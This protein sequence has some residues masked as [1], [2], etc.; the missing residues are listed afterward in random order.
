[1][2]TPLILLSLA[3]V[4]TF[5]LAMAQ[6]PS[7]GWG[8]ARWIWDQADA[9]SVAQTDDPRYVRRAFTL[10]AKPLKAELWIAADN[11]YTAYVNG[12]KVGTGT[13]WSKVD[14]YDVAR[15]LTAGKNVL[16]I[17]AKNHG[18]PAG[19]IAR[20]HIVTADKKDTIVGT[21]EQ[22]RV[23]QIA[24]PDWLKV[25]FDDQ[26]WATAAVLGDVT[27][28]P[29]NLAGNAA[30]GGGGQ[31]SF[32]FQVADA[33]IKAQQKAEDQVKNF[34]LPEGFEIELVASDP[35]V[36][37]P[38]TMAVD[39]QGRIYV[40][41]S[42][43]YRYGPSGSPIKPYA[44]PLVRLDPIKPQ[45]GVPAT[46]ARYKR[47]LIADGFDDPVMGIAVKGDKLWVTANNYLYTY[48]LPA[49]PEGESLSPGGSQ[50]LT[51]NPS[52][53]R[54]EGGKKP[55]GLATN[56]KTI[57]IDK[58]KAWNP[59][60]MFV[61]EWGPDGMLYMSVGN[62]GMDLQGPD[63]KITSRGGSGIIVRMN[64]DGSK[65]ERLV[66]GLRVPY[67]FEMD[68]FGQLWLLSNGEGNPDRFVRV[69][70]GVDYHCFSRSGVDNV[71]LAGNHPLAPPCFEL[72][73]GAHTQLMRYY[74][75]AFPK[76]YQGSLLACNWGSHGFP[77]LNRGIFRYVPDERNNITHKEPFVM[78]SD[79]YFRP[80]HIF[81]DPDG[82]L[83]IADWY[84]RDD[85]SDLTGRIWRVK[86]T[87][88]EP[89]PEVKHRLDSPEWTDFNYALSALGSPHHLIRERAM[90]ELTPKAG[91]E[92]FACLLSGHAEGAKEPLGAANALWALVRN[93]GALAQAGLQG[94][95]LSPDWRV[96]RL[97]H[98]SLR[99]FNVSPELPPYAFP[100]DN[101]PA[102][103]IA[104]AL[105]LKDDRARFQSLHS[106]LES[107][108]AADPHLRYEAA[109]HLAKDA[110]EERLLPLLSSPNPD[111]QMAALIAIDVACYENMPTKKAALA[112]L[113]KALN[114][115]GKLDLTLALQVAQ[116]NGDASLAP[117]LEKLVAR[118][119]VPVG[120][121]AK[122]LLVLKSK[123]GSFGSA[124]SGKAGKRFVEAVEK[125][126]IK[127]TTPGDQLLLFEFLEME[128][129][130]DFAL[131]QI[132]GQV[133][134]GQPQTRSAALLLA[135]K[136]GPKSG[137][138]AGTLWP[139]VLNPKTK[140]DDAA[141]LLATL[142]AI[143]TPPNADKW[144]QLVL[145]PN[146]LLRTDAVRWWRTFKG[147]PRMLEFLEKQAPELVKDDPALRDD[148]G[149]VFRHL[150]VK[151]SIDV[152]DPETDKA[153]L[154]KL[155]LDVLAKMPAAEKTTRA[156]LGKQVF[157][158]TGCTRCHTTATQTTPL[159]PS[160]KG[161]AAQKVDYLIESVLYP[162]KVIKTGFE[163]ERIVT[164][165]GRMLTGLVKEDGAF[166][167]VLNL[168]QDVR[169]AKTAVEERH[170]QKISVMPEGQESLMSRREFVDLM[171]Y[172]GTLK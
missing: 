109:W 6:S 79:P 67:S 36:I 16:A 86:Y 75:A 43:T 2:K 54:G 55:A 172:L 83:L 165:D 152:P 12:Q 129:P 168:D 61:L 40:S 122:G 139:G 30:S 38:V 19:L 41:E 112:A 85:E 155:S 60:G 73:R 27:I 8:S 48:D 59:F 159:A 142:A 134:S 71:W 92:S 70:E 102:V 39:E 89:R 50:P 126:A 107:G 99:R 52:P 141:D 169:I 14:R 77:G 31:K 97:A 58:N 98:N 132:A 4:F 1:M 66:Q 21:D 162:S 65:M 127:V 62:H 105:R 149:A 113:G 106:S 160:L 28:G 7:P 103:R 94:G 146:R 145:G 104:Q 118:H 88:K 5:P 156:V 82:N 87:G 140:A 33:K 3:L 95:L 101:D 144:Q 158:R 125:G 93:N 56:K 121:I 20:L 26:G 44:N 91:K 25:D 24:H 90:R 164:K 49:T 147:Q 29:W 10:A 13:E 170:L 123:T 68:P 22:T 34:I 35:L 51:P 17:V 137:R 64:P 120:V 136:F 138:V 150:G 57:V 46:G 45:P 9:N 131:K 166:L 153:A 114:T 96:R 143:E 167:R 111:V 74:A 18:G 151:S 81:L 32:Q 130:T 23:T 124:A 148:L 116:L 47:V 11:E 133:Y 42:H 115:P 108:A 157:E 163:T 100:K 15:H 110:N 161:I 37:N 128:G 78:C 53:Q 154:T 72:H 76:A 84:G 135:R 69:I 117:A 63:G 80:S 119:D 171:A